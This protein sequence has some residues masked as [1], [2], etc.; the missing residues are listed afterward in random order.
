MA[1]LQDTRM[2]VQVIRCLFGQLGVKEQGQVFSVR[3]DYKDRT[4]RN[5]R[6][7]QKSH[8]HKVQNPVNGVSSVVSILK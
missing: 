5:L 6:D 8:G 7:F 2:G 1:W 3:T 4:F